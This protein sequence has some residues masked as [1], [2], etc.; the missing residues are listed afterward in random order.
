MTHGGCLLDIILR[1]S[2]EKYVNTRQCVV[3]SCGCCVTVVLTVGHGTVPGE[4]ARR[5]DT[6]P[7]F[8]NEAHPAREKV[9]IF[10]ICVDGTLWPSPSINPLDQGGTIYAEGGGVCL[11]FATPQKLRPL[12][13]RPPMT[14]R[15]R[16]RAY[17]R[18]SASKLRPFAKSRPPREKA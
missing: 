18:D 3:Y 10:V 16:C 11:R 15:S 1:Q 12:A 4:T 13:P 6:L 5:R 2:P 7:T 8:L 17:C 9:G 14:M